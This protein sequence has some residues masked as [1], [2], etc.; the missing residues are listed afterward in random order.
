MG[1][2]PLGPLASFVFSSGAFA[3]DTLA[4]FAKPLGA[5]PFEMFWALTPMTT[6]IE[7]WG[8]S[9]GPFP[10]DRDSYWLSLSAC[11]GLF[12]VNFYPSFPIRVTVFGFWTL[13]GSPVV[14]HGFNFIVGL[15]WEG[16]NIGGCHVWSLNACK[17]DEDVLFTLLLK[18][19]PTAMPLVVPPLPFL[20]SISTTTSSLL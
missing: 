14:F 6:V 18:P 1:N 8:G 3:S 10:L 7:A 4:S 15:G 19:S 2:H 11:L 5:V 17:R 16:R 9:L 20:D 13:S 12:R